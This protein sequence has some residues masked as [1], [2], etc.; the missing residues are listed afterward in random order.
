MHFHQQ[1]MKRQIVSSDKVGKNFFRRNWEPSYS[2]TALVRMG[3]PGDGEKWVCDPHTSLSQNDAEC[4]I[5]SIGSNNE[6]SSERA[7]SILDARYTRLMAPCRPIHQ[8][9][10]LL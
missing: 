4:I 1:Q 7:I 10:L 5:Y 2:C 9:N 6:F 8:K 3:C